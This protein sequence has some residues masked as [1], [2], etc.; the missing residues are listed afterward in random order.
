MKRSLASHVY[1]KFLRT[2]ETTRKGMPRM[3]SVCNL[4]LNGNSGSVE[5]QGQIS[6]IAVNAAPDEG[7]AG[8]STRV[9]VRATLMV[10]A[11]I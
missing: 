3:P 7:K 8:Q 1:L 6:T 10:M 5:T 2:V 11:E 4:N 9:F